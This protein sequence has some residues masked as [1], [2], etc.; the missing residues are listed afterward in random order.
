[1]SV[2]G[3][4]PLGAAARDIHQFQANLQSMSHRFETS[5]QCFCSGGCG[6]VDVVI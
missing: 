3:L 6:V 4:V 1:M 2:P 5:M